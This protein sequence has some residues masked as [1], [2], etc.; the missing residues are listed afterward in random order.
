M[1]VF[2]IWEP[3][4][5]HH[6]KEYGLRHTSL[7]C[8]HTLNPWYE[9]NVYIAVKHVPHTGRPVLSEIVKNFK[10]V[11]INVKFDES[12]KKI[13][14]SLNI[15]AKENRANYFKNIYNIP[16]SE[17]IFDARQKLMPI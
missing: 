5:I 4:V 9:Y 14:S 11:K 3:R 2:Y 15:L 17:L 10:I 12:L 1:S 8:I 16:S 6:L 7:I 13:E